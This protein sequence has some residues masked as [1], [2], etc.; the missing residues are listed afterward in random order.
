MDPKLAQINLA[1]TLQLT[2]LRH[3]SHGF[4]CMYNLLTSVNVFHVLM[5]AN[6]NIQPSAAYK[7]PAN[8]K[9]H[10]IC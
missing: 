10:L 3:N 6:Y 5:Y 7:P 4:K 9:M 1:G 8:T 2:I